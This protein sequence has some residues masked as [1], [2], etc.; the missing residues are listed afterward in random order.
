MFSLKE[1]GIEPDLVIVVLVVIAIVLF[2]MLAVAFSKIGK[3]K[4]RYMVFMEGED[5][6]SLEVAFRKRFSN[7]DEI[8]EHLDKIDD[9]LGRIDSNLLEAYQKISVVKYDAFKEIGG[10]LSFVLVLLNNNDDGFILNSM[11]SNSDGCYIY[12]KEVKGGAPFVELSEEERQA[13]DDAMENGKI[14]NIEEL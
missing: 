2:I 13:L 4:K 11:H 9:H 8:N 1:M 14:M 7:M 3:M 5:G 12:I 10:T 6:K